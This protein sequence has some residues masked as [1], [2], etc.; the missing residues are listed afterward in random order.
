MRHAHP[1]A[2]ESDLDE[3][4]VKQAEASRDA[5]L[6]NIPIGLGISSELKRAESTLRIAATKKP[7]TAPP[8]LYFGQEELGYRWILKNPILPRFA[9]PEPAPTN[10]H[11][12]IERWPPALNFGWSIWR[13]MMRSRKH[14]VDFWWKD[15]GT[16]ESSQPRERNVVIVS[17]GKVIEPVAVAQ[18][19]L[20]RALKDIPLLGH[21]DILRVSVVWENAP[22]EEPDGEIIAIDHL[23]CPLR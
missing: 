3:L 19:K 1:N 21:A 9:N 8:T 11:E 7:G 15:D 22:N 20:V 13:I 4:G 2:E 10:A 12:L 5:Y 14:F 16:W 6:S 17:H 18:K 23:P